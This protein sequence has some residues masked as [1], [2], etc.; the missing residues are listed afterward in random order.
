MRWQMWVVLIS[1]GCWDNVILLTIYCD[2]Q[3]ISRAIHGMTNAFC[4]GVA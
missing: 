3:S 1:A 2:A 4:Q